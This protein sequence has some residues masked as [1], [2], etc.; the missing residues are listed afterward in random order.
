MNDRSTEHKVL[1]STNSAHSI[2]GA[3]K[4]YETVWYYNWMTRQFRQCSENDPSACE[5]KRHQTH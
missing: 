5:Y 1:Y 2:S 3:R 4:I